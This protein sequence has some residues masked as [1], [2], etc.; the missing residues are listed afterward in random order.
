MNA[1]VGG[2]TVRSASSLPSSRR[3]MDGGQGVGRGREGGQPWGSLG[4]WRGGSV[5]S[6]GCGGG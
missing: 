1:R 6:V 5:M 2:V 3:Y 4:A